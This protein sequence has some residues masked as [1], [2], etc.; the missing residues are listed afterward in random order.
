MRRL[1]RAFWGVLLAA[2]MAAPTASR[3]DTV[4][5]L[6]GNFTI[7]QYCGLH[8]ASQLVEV[9]YVIVFGQLPALRELHAADT[10]GDGVTSQAERDAYIGQL[11]P[12][13][14]KNLELKVDGSTLPLHATH[15]LSSLPTE[16]GGF[17]LRVDVD[18][19][20]ALPASVGDATRR[21]E[22]T[23]RNYAGRMGWHEIVVKPAPGL[24]VFDTLSYST[25]LTG[26]LTEALQSLPAAGPLDERTARLSFGKDA[27]PGAALLRERAEDRTAVVPLRGNTLTKI[28]GAMAESQWLAVRT[29]QLV[30]AIS[31]PHVP[32]RITLAALL[33]A[34]LLGAVH[35]LSPGHGKTIVG[36]YLIGSR[37]TPRHAAFL[38]LTVTVTH[39]IGVFILGFATLYASRY[40]VPERLFPLLSL[41]SALLVLGMG[42]VLLVQRGRAARQ[43][44]STIDVTSVRPLH[45]VKSEAPAPTGARGLI[46]APVAQLVD[47]TMHSHGGGPMH[48][49]LPPGATGERISWR[50]L[51]TLGVSGGLVPCPSAMVLLL[52]AIAL[53]KTA[54]GMLL[55]VAFSVGLAITLTLIGVAFLY[56]RNRFGSLSAGGRWAA[57]LPA[58]SAGA[59]TMIGVVLCFGALRSFGS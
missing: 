28:P 8:L 15:W 23:N 26:G 3:A 10:D 14:A 57:L 52:A 59:I 32:R 31:G 44:L 49:H 19:T 18:F 34:L 1:K 24:V 9:H 25:S 21:L 43:A 39:T 51:L 33:G 48:S 6:L 7:N 58:L 12:G 53:N 29:R 46:F 40:I 50:S 16:Q 5:S 11:A 35:A 17:S 42:I 27:P 38:G 55:V 54:Y 20:A 30:D 41:T 56:A 47:A 22:F 36:A 13:L 45:F 4:A 2:T 37:G